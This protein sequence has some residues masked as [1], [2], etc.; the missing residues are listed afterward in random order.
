MTDSTRLDWATDP[1]EVRCLIGVGSGKGGVGK[2]TVAVNLAVA[3]SGMGARTGL[4]DVDMY[5]PSVPTM[6]GVNNG[7]MKMDS[8]ERILPLENHGVKLVSI[9]FMVQD[10][11]ALIWRGAILDKVVKDFIN[12][13]KW[14]GL[15]YLIVDLP[16]GTGDVPLSLA[17]AA[18]LNGV[19]L[20]TT[21]QEVAIADVVRCFALYQEIKVPVLGLVENMSTLVCPHCQ[22]QVELFTPGGGR[23]L[24][25]SLGIP[26]LG[27]IPF[28][29]VIGLG[30]DMGLPLLL[31]EPNSP[32]SEV[33][34]QI[35]RRLMN[36]AACA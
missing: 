32:S 13:V 8:E 24:S 22:G 1:E 30:G 18:S 25:Q 23:D 16:P 10:G 31:A 7:R 4:L 20:V 29:T 6:M 17:N 14:G 15:D 11:D 35:A 33:F 5:G 34:R 26:L 2:S 27:Q 3:L 9:G 28:D 36:S 12:N 19:V 21:P